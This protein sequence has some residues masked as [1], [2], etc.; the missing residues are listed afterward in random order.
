M[1]EVKGLIGYHVEPAVASEAAIDRALERHYGLAEKPPS[2]APRVGPTLTLDD[3]A[4]V[5]LADVNL[6]A[7]DGGGTEGGVDDQ[8]ERSMDVDLGN[9][10]KAADT[11]PLEKLTN[12]LLVDCL[13]RGAAEIHVEP[14]EREFRVRYRIDGILYNVMAL[15]MRLR[16]P[17]TVRLKSMGRLDVTER[18]FPQAGRIRIR[19][20][21]EDRSR[22]ADYAITTLPTRWGEKTVLRFLDRSRLV[23][24]PAHLGLEPRALERFRKSLCQPHGVVLLAGPGR[25]GKSHTLYSALCAL[26]RP[27]VNIVTFEAPVL[28]DLMGINQ[29]E[30]GP[31]S[32]DG[33]RALVRSSLQQDADIVALDPIGDDA[34]VKEVVRLGASAGRLFLATLAGEDAIAALMAL[35]ER[36]GRPWEVA[37][38]VRSIVAQR[39]VRRLCTNCRA[40]VG[41]IDPKLLVD[42][43]FPLE[44]AGSIKV[45]QGTGCSDCNRTGYRGRLALFEVLEMTD[46]LR[47]L[48]RVGATVEGIRRRALEEGL[49][50]LRMSGLEQAKAGITTLDEVLRETSL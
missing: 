30:V 34:T 10:L 28:F 50:T 42:V 47:D 15:P 7:L 38:A 31:Q 23:V 19:I 9:L 41:G 25:S 44:A 4:G 35:V 37:R 24:D 49:V 43:G 22:E 2:E 16:E 8:P 32:A 46:G 5:S 29:V 40:E 21:W 14:Y 33:L 17:L 36:S 18:R 39:M 27:D 1:D 6:D 13:K 12:V 20:R 48:V 11:S 45:Y 3:M 26:N